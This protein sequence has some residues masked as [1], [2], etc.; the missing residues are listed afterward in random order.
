M[1]KSFDENTC[2]EFRMVL[3]YLKERW[4]CSDEQ[5]GEKIGCSVKTV[6]SMRNNPLGASSRY[7]ERVRRYAR[8]EHKKEASEEAEEIRRLL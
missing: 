2:I 6:S 1:A 5:L 3:A 4:G 8:L 7:T